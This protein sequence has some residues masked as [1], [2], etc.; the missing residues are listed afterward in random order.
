MR[1]GEKIKESILGGPDS[2]SSPR[3]VGDCTKSRRSM[4]ETRRDRVARRYTLATQIAGQL[5]RY[6]FLNRKGNLIEVGSFG[7]VCLKDLGADSSDPVELHMAGMSWLRQNS[8]L[9]YE[10]TVLVNGGLDFF[11]R[12]LELPRLKKHEVPDA[13]AWEVEKQIPIPVKES[14]LLLKQSR[15]PEGFIDVIAAA[16]PRR[17]IDCW[18]HLGTRLAGIAPVPV[19]LAGLGPKSE[20]R[21]E[22][23]CYVYEGDSVIDIGFYNSSGL[24]YVHSTGAGE[25]GNQQPSGEGVFSRERIL[26]EL[27]N[28]IE[29]F[30]GRFPDMTIKRILLLTSS[31]NGAALTEMI[32]R[33][34]DIPAATID[35]GS[36]LDRDSR[37]LSLTDPRYL[38]LLGAAL[39]ERDSFLYI[40]ETLRREIRY[41]LINKYRNYLL[42][43]GIVFNALA[44]S[45]WTGRSYQAARELGQVEETK[46]TMEASD[47]YK[48]CL[49]YQSRVRL[50]D[51]LSS[52]L[53]DRDDYHSRFLR[54]L[55]N[56][57]PAGIYLENAA[58]S[59]GDGQIRF[60]VGGY[61]DGDMPKSEVALIRL[62][63][64]FESHGMTQLK[65][66]RL[67]RKVSGERKIESFVLDGRW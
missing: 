15:L 65:L 47:A 64:G 7:E 26:E 9:S 5:F 44:G 24:Q 34:V 19:C 33:R 28:C 57:T 25:A 27:I 31:E 3:P 12:R 62:M 67:G 45:I 60:K 6:A 11:I 61:F 4:M 36:I 59:G 55:S 10:R 46:K 20:S 32:S 22:A 29:I 17:Q 40:P 16:V 50:L 42:A 1:I 43:A 14:Y 49:E 39:L 13:A 38:P 53:K 2:P 30:F 37:E 48:K 41:G 21:E 51:L 56:I 23:Y 35:P 18:N 66:Q 54:V 58:L 52:Q 8:D 63:A